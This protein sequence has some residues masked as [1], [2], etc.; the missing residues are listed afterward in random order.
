MG[1][2]KGNPKNIWQ[3]I[4]DDVFC[5]KEAM[6]SHSAIDGI[7]N[8]AMSL[9]VTSGNLCKMVSPLKNTVKKIRSDKF[10]DHS[11][12]NIVACNAYE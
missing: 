2:S 1:D 5:G 3:D 10:E 7:S 8:K 9:L 12:P 6:A 11:H 4:C